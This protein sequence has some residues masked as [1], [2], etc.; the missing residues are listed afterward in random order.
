MHPPGYGPV[1]VMYYAPSTEKQ[2]F[3]IIA[4]VTVYN[5]DLDSDFTQSYS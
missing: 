1:E 3:K 5:L 4:Q 2:V